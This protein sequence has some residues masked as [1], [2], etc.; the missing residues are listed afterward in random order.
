MWTMDMEE[1]K[2]E[3]SNVSANDVRKYPFEHCLAAFRGV[4]IAFATTRLRQFD[5]HQYPSLP[6]LLH[7]ELTQSVDN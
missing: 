5:R 2:F 1:L 4:G 7:T 3:T 6:V